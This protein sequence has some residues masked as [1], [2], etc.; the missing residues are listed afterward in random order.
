[1]EEFLSPL[2]TSPMV[3]HL[4]G[5][6]RFLSHHYRSWI[7][8]LRDCLLTVPRSTSGPFENFLLRFTYISQSH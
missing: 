2:N 7:Y 5:I 3:S 1:M 6:F 8:I 4:P